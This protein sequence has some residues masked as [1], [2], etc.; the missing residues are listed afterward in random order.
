MF[1]DVEKD[2]R[3]WGGKKV[4]S[5]DNLSVSPHPLDFGGIL[6]AHRGR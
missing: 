3:I 6:A 5:F 2:G 1:T 4:V